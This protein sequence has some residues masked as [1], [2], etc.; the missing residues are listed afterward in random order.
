MRTHWLI[1]LTVLA[2]LAPAARAQTATGEVNGSITDN[3]GAAVPNAT[4]KLKNQATG[5]ETI[6]SSNEYGGFVFVNVQPG[7]YT[8]RVSMAGF[9]E[10]ETTGLVVGVN[11]AATVN[12]KL[13]LGAIAE[14]VEVK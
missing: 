2:P 9:K 4:V 6:P 5:I 13:E 14:T 8:L 1:A 3:S 12:V 7:V 10:A 11:Q